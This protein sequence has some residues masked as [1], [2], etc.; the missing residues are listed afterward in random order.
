LNDGTAL[1][2]RSQLLLQE[3]QPARP[4][5]FD[6][7][8]EEY[9]AI[10]KAIKEE[11]GIGAS[12]AAIIATLAEYPCEMLARYAL[13][14]P[15]GIARKRFDS[16]WIEKHSDSTRRF[17]ER[18]KNCLEKTGKKCLAVSEAEGVSGHFDVLI[19]GNGNTIELLCP[20][21]GLR[22]VIEIKTGA[23]VDLPQLV[24]YLCDC[25]VLILLR[26]NTNHVVKLRRSEFEQ[27][28]CEDLEDG[29]S[30][31][32]RILS[33]QPVLVGSNACKGCPIPCRLARPS[34]SE[35]SFIKL[36]K[37]AFAEDITNLLRNVYSTIESAVFLVLE[38]LQ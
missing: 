32:K 23:S 24:R 28:L 5:K 11:F 33:G 15:S 27:F 18:L 38:E 14:N 10:I 2:D 20:P 7:L 13:M 25:D 31:M 34:D 8:R 12:H 6:C 9:L 19:N 29:L 17:I 26:V 30:K 37:E 36:G 35:A 1:S 22:I 3:A 21:S 16:W 4:S